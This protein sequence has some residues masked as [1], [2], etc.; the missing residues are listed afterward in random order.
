MG[1]RLASRTKD[2]E[3]YQSEEMF[4]LGGDAP[5]SCSVPVRLLTSRWTASSYGTIVRLRSAKRTGVREESTDIVSS[6]LRVVLLTFASPG[7][8]DRVHNNVHMAVGKGLGSWKMI[9]AHSV[10]CKG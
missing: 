9:V 5:T 8:R 7:S 6:I 10:C 2:M 3:C 1:R 4:V